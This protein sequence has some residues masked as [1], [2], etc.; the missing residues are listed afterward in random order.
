MPYSFCVVGGIVQLDFRGK[1]V[2]VVGLARSG[3]AAARALA[4]LGAEVTVTDR[5][6]LDQL[7]PQLKALGSGFVKVAAGG[8]PDRIFRNADLVVLSPGVPKIAPLAEAQRR[9]VKVISELE[10]GWLLSDSLFVGITG[11]NGKSTVTTLVGLMLERAGK[12]VLVAGNIGTALTDDPS[13]LRKKDWIVAE[14]SSFQLEDIDAF[15][16]RVAAVL[17]VTQDHLDRYHGM[18]EYAGAKARIFMNQK[19]DD[20]L[21]LNADDPLVRAMAGLA[22]SQVVLFSRL[23]NIPDGICRQGDAL[24]WKG[25]RLISVDEIRIKGVHNIEN[26]MAAAAL[27]IAAGADNGA[28]AAVLREFPGLEHRL[29]LV[30]E[31][32][33]V[34]FI[35]DSKGT[36]VGAVIKSVEGFTRPVIL[37]AGGL[38]K[39]SDFSPLHGLFKEKVKLLVLIGKAAG[40]MEEA[41]GSATETV[42]AKTLQEAVRLASTKAVSGDVV[43]LSPACASFD[44]FRDFEDRGKQFKD[45][46]MKL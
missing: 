38:D 21:V 10:L 13:G 23:K 27:S 37:I 40:A 17:N 12:Q 30:R 43:L 11:T 42:V 24:L 14:I 25:E 19:K 16:P 9:G 28:V 6:P 7:G 31:K 4:A 2:T 1:K 41:L 45:A 39:G 8:H 44:M 18:D 35:N 22:R 3:V 5:K 15:R 20:V 26:A 34:T 46:V 33:G 36:N 29:E 32:D